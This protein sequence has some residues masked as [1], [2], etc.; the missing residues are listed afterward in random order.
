VVSSSLCLYIVYHCDV[1]ILLHLQVLHCVLALPLLND[2]TYT[3]AVERMLC[4]SMFGSRE[5]GVSTNVSTEIYRVNKIPEEHK[6]DTQVVATRWLQMQ[7]PLTQTRVNASASSLLKSHPADP[8]YLCARSNEWKVPDIE[9]K[10]FI[11][12]RY[13]I[14]TNISTTYDECFTL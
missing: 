2:K 11:E 10:L 6:G 5:V 4:L 7:V 1:I 3:H 13:A 12:F 14:V 8:L 9:G